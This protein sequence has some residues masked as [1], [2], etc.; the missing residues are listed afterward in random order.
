MTDKLEDV[1]A[2]R[3]FPVLRE[4]VRMKDADPRIVITQA[5]L[6]EATGLDEDMVSRS[7]VALSRA[8]LVELLGRMSGYGHVSNVSP[9]AYQLVGLWPDASDATDRVLWEIER[10]IETATPEER[11]KLQKLRDGVVGVGRDLMT[12]V[13]ASVI[14]KQING[15]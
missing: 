9:A 2:S 14:T 4:A 12:D 1:W 8:G 3:D 6:Q 11:T 5:Q 13:M 7:I 15:A 10:R